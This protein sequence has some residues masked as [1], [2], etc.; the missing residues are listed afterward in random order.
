[1]AQINKTTWYI[2]L[3]LAIVL[4]LG[5]CPRHKAFDIGPEPDWVYPTPE[6]PVRE[7]GGEKIV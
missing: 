4:G 5:G 2:P 1:M 3:V 7:Y 6:L